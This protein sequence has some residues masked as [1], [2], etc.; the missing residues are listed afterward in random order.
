MTTRTYRHWTAAERAFVIDH[1]GPLARRPWT[2]RAI[3]RALGKT[4]A[5]VKAAARRYGRCWRY[6]TTPTDAYFLR[7]VRRMHA[8]GMSDLRIAR[9]QDCSRR[10]VYCARKRM[11]LPPV[12]KGG[13]P[14][15]RPEHIGRIRELRAQGATWAQVAAACG[16]SATSA[17][18]YWRGE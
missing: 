4:T 3:A 15:R 11:G 17:K 12:A 7:E 13:F 9:H 6:K 14:S 10:T 16:V 2:T 8:L 5:E 1:Y 18:R